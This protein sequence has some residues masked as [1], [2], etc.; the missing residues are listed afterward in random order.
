MFDLFLTLAS[1]GPKPL[2]LRSQ[3]VWR[4]KLMILALISIACFSD[5][6]NSLQAML[7]CARISNAIWMDA[8]LRDV[9][10]DSFLALLSFPFNF[11]FYLLQGLSQN[12]EIRVRKNCF[13]GWMITMKDLLSKCMSAVEK[14]AV[15]ISKNIKKDLIYMSYVL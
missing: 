9:N 1:F 10:S 6:S 4:F 14:W 15:K 7:I 11:L 13:L 8:F 5:I 2:F 3:G 12:F